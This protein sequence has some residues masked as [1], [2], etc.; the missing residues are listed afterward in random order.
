MLYS[1]TVLHGN[2]NYIEK[3]VAMLLCCKNL[4]QPEIWDMQ[5]GKPSCIQMSFGLLCSA[6]HVC[7]SYGDSPVSDGCTITSSG[8]KVALEKKGGDNLES[9][10]TPQSKNLTLSVGEPKKESSKTN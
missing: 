3:C 10:S 7:H 2:I 1:I 5:R 6:V 9:P 4:A 8:I